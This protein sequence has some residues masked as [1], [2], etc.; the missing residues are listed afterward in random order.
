MGDCRESHFGRTGKSHS[1]GGRSIL[2]TAFR[3][4]SADD[5]GVAE[6]QTYVTALHERLEEVRS[7]VVRRLADALAA[8][9]VNN[10][11]A[12]GERE[13]AVRLHTQRLTSIDAADS[14][15]CFG[16]L[17]RREADVPRYVGRIGLL[18]EDGAAEP[19]L[20]DWRAPAAQPVYTPPAAHPH[21]RPPRGGRGR[22]GAGPH[23]P[24]GDRLRADRRGGAA[25]GAQHLPHR[26]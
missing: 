25:R 5:A 6:E 18:A 26:P 24:G 17:D 4:S 15:L 14:G 7:L 12:I 21:P 16:R 13:A 22:R 3:D 20:V 11:Q 19:L 9:A 10:P 2:S 8:P 23:R 1:S